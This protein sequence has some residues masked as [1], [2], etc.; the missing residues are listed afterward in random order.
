MKTE[1]ETQAINKHKKNWE[2]VIRT[3]STDRCLYV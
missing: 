3:L 1:Q 2:D